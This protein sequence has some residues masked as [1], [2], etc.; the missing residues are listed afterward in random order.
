MYFNIIITFNDI[1]FL[2]GLA[3]LYAVFWVM[4]KDYLNDKDRYK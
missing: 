3:P 4:F 2:I 1:L